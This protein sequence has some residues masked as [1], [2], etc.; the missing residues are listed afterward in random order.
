MPTDKIK[1]GHNRSLNSLKVFTGSIVINN[2][3]KKAL[4]EMVIVTQKSKS[5]LQSMTYTH[6]RIQSMVHTLRLF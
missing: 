2:R 6:E 4:D 3:C 1:D 5:T